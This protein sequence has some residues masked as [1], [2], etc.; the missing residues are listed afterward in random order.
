MTDSRVVIQDTITGAFARAVDKAP[1]NIFLDFSGERYSYAEVARHSTEIAHGLL[2]AGVVPGEVVATMLDNSLEAVTAWL[3]I[4]M[5]GAVSAPVN[6]AFKGAFLRNQLND[7]AAQVVIAENEYG[8]R[9]TAIADELPAVRRLVT[10]TECVTGAT[11]LETTTLDALRRSGPSLPVTARPEDLAILIYTSGTTGPAKG[12]MIPHNVPCN[13]AW[14]TVLDRNYDQ[15]AVLWSPLPLFH[16]N[17]IGAT[18]MAAMMAMGT[19]AIS[20]RFSLSRFW[21]E[22]EKSGATTVN[23]LGSMASLIAEAPDNESAKRC[24][25]QLKH[26]SASPFPP[27]ALQKWRDRF[28]VHAKGALGYGMT[29]VP[30]VSSVR[31]GDP[32]GPPGTSGKTGRDFEVKILDDSDQELEIGA[33]GEIAVRPKMPNIMFQGYWNRPADTVK[34]WR[35]LW[36]HTGDLGKLSEEGDLYFVDRKKDCIRRRGENISS[37]EMEAVFGDHPALLDVAVHAV[38]SPLG[39]DEVKLTAQLKPGAILAEEDLCRWSIERVPYFAVPL[40]IE[41]RDNLPR[42]PTGKVLKEQLR[43]EGKTERTW[44]RE[45]AGL[46][47]QRR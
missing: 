34:A 20:P 27:A 5:I 42:S 25:G 38:L 35:N 44:D 47:F 21:P 1:D 39:E 8:D 36:F 11:A 2:D 28:G 32:P 17:A 43:K 6:T 40:Y 37:A 9:V 13:L 14:N 10:K 24:Y 15:S 3:A 33:V 12:C 7:C 26:V 4:N 41:F 46:T 31:E 16:L 45:A 22:V 18:V 30:T 19:A 23:L 29:E